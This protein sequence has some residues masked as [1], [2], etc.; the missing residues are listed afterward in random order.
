MARDKAADESA[1]DL[2][3]SDVIRGEARGS[4]ARKAHT[5]I[6]VIADTCWWDTASHRCTSGRVRT[7]SGLDRVAEEDLVR[8]KSV[9]ARSGAPST[10]APSIRGRD[11][12]LA[13]R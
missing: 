7:V 11:I 10:A 2:T 6:G 13:R 9:Q 4:H 5:L 1:V 12:L 8:N 3:G